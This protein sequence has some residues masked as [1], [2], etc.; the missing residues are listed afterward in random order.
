MFKLFLPVFDS[1][2]PLS[3][4]LF[5]RP[6]AS[7]LLQYSDHTEGLIGAAILLIGNE[8]SR[9]DIPNNSTLRSSTAR[10]K[11]T[12]LKPVPWDTTHCT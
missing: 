5:S 12:R 7:I 4:S 10:K 2:F 9:R 6:F 1:S 8:L 3:N 11:F